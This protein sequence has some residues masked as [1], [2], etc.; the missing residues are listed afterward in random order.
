VTPKITTL[1]QCTIFFET[2]D[3]E[4]VERSLERL[5]TTI[6]P[7]HADWSLRPGSPASS[8]YVEVAGPSKASVRRLAC[9]IYEVLEQLGVTFAE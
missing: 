3:E 4:S 6:D 2:D 9:E 8:P 5:A 1:Y 7:D